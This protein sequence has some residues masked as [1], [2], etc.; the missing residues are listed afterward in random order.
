MMR[1]LR[2]RLARLHL[3]LRC[4]TPPG[5]C[6]VPC[7]R[8]RFVCDV[9]LRSCH[10][11]HCCFKNRFRHTE[12]QLPNMPNI[13]VSLIFMLCFLGVLNNARL[14]ASFYLW[15]NPNYTKGTSVRTV[16][17]RVFFFLSFVS[18]NSFLQSTIVAVSF[19][20]F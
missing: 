11:P 17:S 6:N 15:S 13:Y 14:N 8:L 20:Y 7:D 10:S 12:Y 9:A 3:H 18:S 19:T 1:L 16:Y 4:L 2:K 5:S